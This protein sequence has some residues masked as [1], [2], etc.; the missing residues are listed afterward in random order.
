MVYSSIQH[1]LDVLV[2]RIRDA[3]QGI[4]PTSVLLHQGLIASLVSSF[5]YCSY[6]WISVTEIVT[7]VD[8]QL[9]EM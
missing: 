1:L 2:S 4:W 9:N 7:V 6:L 3:F 8:G 5:Q